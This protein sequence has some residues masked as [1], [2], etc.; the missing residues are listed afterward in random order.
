MAY[1]LHSL[2]LFIIF[3]ADKSSQILHYD[4]ILYKVFLQYSLYFIKL[5]F[6]ISTFS[7]EFIK[8]VMLLKKRGAT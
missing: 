8:Q 3:V 7:C 5:C 2:F 4:G 1:A 6:E